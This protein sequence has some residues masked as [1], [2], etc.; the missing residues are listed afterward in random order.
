MTML[1]ADQSWD[2]LDGWNATLWPMLLFKE[3]MAQYAEERCALDAKEASATRVGIADA[4]QTP[5][6]GQP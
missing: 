2:K 1:L 3:V 5:A 4:M 6:E